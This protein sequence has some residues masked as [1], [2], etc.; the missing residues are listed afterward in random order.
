[1][2]VRFCHLFVGPGV[3]YPATPP[4]P[5]TTLFHVSL[6]KLLPAIFQNSQNA[7]ISR[8]NN[9]PNIRCISEQHLFKSRPSRTPV[10]HRQLQPP[11]KTPCQLSSRGGGPR[12]KSRTSK[13]DRTCREETRCR[14]AVIAQLSTLKLRVYTVLQ[15]S[16]VTMQRRL[17]KITIYKYK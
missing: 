17:T 7:C 14:H 3:Y 8:C 13:T 10:E 4:H 16:A 15:W 2:A 12:V 1:M 9:C 11:K 5:P 6:H